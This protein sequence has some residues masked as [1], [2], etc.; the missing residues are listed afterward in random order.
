MKTSP[1]Q[2]NSNLLCTMK[3]HLLLVSLARSDISSQRMNHLSRST[4]INLKL[5]R[6]TQK[7]QRC[8]M[9]LS[10]RKTEQ[11]PRWGS[12][13]DAT[14]VS[15]LTSIIKRQTTT[16]ISWRSKKT[17]LHLFLQLREQRSLVLRLRWKKYLKKIPRL[18]SSKTH[19][20]KLY[21]KCI[22]N[23]QGR[24]KLRRMLSSW[25]FQL[26]STRLFN[27]IPKLSTLVSLLAARF[28]VALFKLLISH[29]RIKSLRLQQT[30]LAK[31]SLA[32]RSLALT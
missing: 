27:W 20:R 26:I 1:A 22:E 11:Q 17:Q 15:A 8:P 30:R 24:L 25:L 3:T 7:T 14:R 9:H 10:I 16:K 18:L 21:Y 6:R 4:I 28:S 23:R 12:K 13:T 32:M 31:N 2:R 29:K 5:I 19:K